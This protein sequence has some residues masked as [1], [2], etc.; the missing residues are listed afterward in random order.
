MEFHEVASI[1]PLLEGPEFNRLVED[2][3]TNGLIEPI[4]TYQ[5]KIIDG[6]NRYRA[7]IEAGVELQ[8]REWD[9]E[10]SLVEFVISVNIKRRNQTTSQLAATG[11]LLEPMFKPG[12]LARMLAGKKL[13]PTPSSAEGMGEA[14]EQAARAVGVGHTIIGELKAIKVQSEELFGKVFRGELTVHAAK[15][16]IQKQQAA[17]LDVVLPQGKYRTIVIDLPWPMEKIQRRVSPNQIGFEYPTMTAQ[18]LTDFP[19][20]DFA[21]DNCHLYVWTTHKH[22]PL[23]LKIVEHWDFK[24]Q[25]L[26]TWVKNVGF[27]PFSWMYSTEHVLFCRRGNL[28]LLEKGVRLDFSA[29]VR[30]HSRKPDEFYEIVKA[31]SPEPRIDVFSREERTGFDSW[32]NE[33]GKFKAGKPFRETA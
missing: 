2:I 14:R 29:K 15:L 30:E 3:K 1:F 16:A 18:E 19:V 32:G 23:A 17:E 33:C 24:Y 25:C 6:R 21:H 22:L 28:D 5:G 20:V 7:C 10:G 11:V 8:Y 31:V 26:M 27:T 4:W 13:D 9:R 12:A